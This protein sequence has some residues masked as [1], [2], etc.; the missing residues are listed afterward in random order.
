MTVDKDIKY[1]WCITKPTD[2]LKELV[3]AKCRTGCFKLERK[4]TYKDG[5][6][7]VT[8]TGSDGKEKTISRVKQGTR[9]YVCPK[10]QTIIRATR[11][12][13]VICGDCDLTMEQP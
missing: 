12:V 3:K 5:T 9:K 8:T 11:E 7:K 6:P 10:C 13:N 1:G 4:K 2:E